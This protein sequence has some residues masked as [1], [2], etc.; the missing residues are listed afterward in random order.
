MIFPSLRRRLSATAA[1]LVVGSLALT[2]CGDAADE[3]TTTA[4]DGNGGDNGVI[5]ITGVP[6]EEAT[7]LVSKFELLMEVISEETGKEVEFSSSTDYAAVIEALVAGQADMAIG[8]PF[9]YVRASKAGAEL[10]PLGAAS[11]RRATSRVTSPTLSSD[12][13]PTS[14]SWPTPRGARSATSTRV[15]PPASS[16]RPPV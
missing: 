16:T 7:A 10:E 8:S 12:R 13:A 11:R 4:A 5:T 9:S 2:A 15:P 14:G 1:A 6:A 3:T